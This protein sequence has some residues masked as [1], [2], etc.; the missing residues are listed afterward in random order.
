MRDA[1]L[2]MDPEEA[3][4]LLGHL[5]QVSSTAETVNDPRLVSWT[6]ATEG[7]AWLHA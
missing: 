4:D 7:S 1:C 2:G 3:L 5:E 6:P